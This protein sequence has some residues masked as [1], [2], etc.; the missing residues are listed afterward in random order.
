M[1]EQHPLKILLVEDNIINQ[2]M[3]K[4]MLQ[5]M[6]YQPSVVNNGL[7][8]LSALRRQLYDVV[9]MDIQ[10]PEMDGLT[11]TQHIKQGWTLE[12]QPWIIALTASAMW[13]ERDRCLESGMND[14]LVKPIR[15]AELMQTLRRCQPIVCESATD[16]PS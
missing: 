1:A 12:T 11:A 3:I 2:R 14:Y 5:R 10:M 9:L 16:S 7:E 15:I 4:L 8:A 13:G 6:G